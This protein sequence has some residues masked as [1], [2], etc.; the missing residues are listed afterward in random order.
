MKPIVNR[1]LGA[2]SAAQIRDGKIQGAAKAEAAAR[3]RNV[4]RENPIIGPFGKHLKQRL[5]GLLRSNRNG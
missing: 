4:R 1:S 5:S 3:W 2:V